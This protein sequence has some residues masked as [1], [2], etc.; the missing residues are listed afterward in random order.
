MTHS[1]NEQ[2][3]DIERIDPR[4]SP[5]RLPIVVAEVA[6]RRGWRPAAAVV[7]RN[8]DAFAS[9]APRYLL[10]ALKALPGE[11]FVETPGLVVAANYL[12]QVVING[13]PRR[14]FHDGRLVSQLRQTPRTDLNSLILLTG[15]SA[16]ARTAGRLEEA[17]ATADEAREAVD[18]LSTA[19]RA[20][21][22]GSLPH[23]RF[24][25]GRSLDAADAPGAVFEYQEAYDLGLLTGQPVI[26]RRAAGHLAWYHADRGRLRQADLWLSRAQAQPPSNGRYDVIVLLTDA[27]LRY[28]RGDRSAGQELGR[29]LGLPLGE[30]WAAAIWVSAMLEHTQA[31]ASSVH[32]RM[33]SELE[34]HPE[35]EPLLGANGR[36]LKA[37]RAR[38]ARIRPR[39]RTRAPLP[40]SPNAL[41][42]LLAASSALRDDRY[43]EALRHSA[44][45]T[46]VTAAPRVEA[47]AHLIAAAAHHAVNHRTT[48]AEAFRLANGIIGQE[49]LLSAYSFVPA[50]TVAA[51]AQL[52][53]EDIHGEVDTVRDAPFP[54]L[55]KREREVLVLLTTGLSMSRIADELYISP[56]TLKSLVRRVYRKLDVNSRAEAV[57]IATSAG[58]PARGH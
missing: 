33:E 7:E 52:A 46:A 58:L 51:L 11:A 44:D 53:G 41:D 19:D 28:E 4:R 3:P 35:A 50:P 15:Q 5:H 38:L 57:D 26:A 25:W 10:A 54:K 39:L 29:A 34:H 8:W 40:G 21:L 6:A 18:G 32:A 14:F 2:P 1:D 47:A 49:R 12:Q 16:G 56:N 22:I 24:Q 48:A 31:G 30:Q 55:T 13:D 37:A 17:R 45:A 27:L 23:L 9:Q 43:D 42:H 36:Y 20:P